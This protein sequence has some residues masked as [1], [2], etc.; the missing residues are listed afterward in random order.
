MTPHVCVESLG[1]PLCPFVSDGPRGSPNLPSSQCCMECFGY[2]SMSQ[3]CQNASI[4]SGRP[5]EIR[6][7]VSIGRV[8]T[9]DQDVVLAEMLDHL[10]RRMKGIHHDKIG[11]RIDRFERP[12]H[13]LIEKFLT[14]VCVAP[15]EIINRIDVVQR[16]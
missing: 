2:G 10:L 14:V 7:C 9:S 4:S 16:G 12:C 3:V 8:R 6:M 11:V 1:F 15:N 5:R 13:C